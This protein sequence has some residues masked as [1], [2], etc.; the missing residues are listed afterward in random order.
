MIRTPYLLLALAMPLSLARAQDLGEGFETTP[1]EVTPEHAR[2][3]ERGL[4]WLAAHQN[5]DGSWSYNQDTV[6]QIRGQAEPFHHTDRNTL[7]KVGEPSPNPLA[8]S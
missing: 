7:F 4:D 1:I 3:V 5:A 2:A 6:L 8:A